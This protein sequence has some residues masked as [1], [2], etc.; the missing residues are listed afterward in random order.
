MHKTPRRKRLRMAL[1]ALGI[2]IIAPINAEPAATNAT[3]G[4]SRCSAAE[5]HQLDFWVGDW[6]TYESHAPE[7]DV[8]ARARV[9]SVAQGCAIYERYEQ[10]DGLIGESLLSYDSVRKQWQ[11]TWI[12]NRGAN[13]VLW[14]NLKDGA[15]VLEGEV[16]L[17]DGSTLMQRISWKPHDKGVREWAVLSRDGGKTWSPAF[18]V[19]FLKHRNE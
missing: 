13:M 16:H 11:Q 5:Y 19:L 14:G 18:D 15:L 8:V 9:E 17:Q 12:T 3:V 7:G 6:D 2:A 4:S 1:T 10:V